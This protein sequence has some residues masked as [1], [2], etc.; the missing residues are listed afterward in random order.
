MNWCAILATRARR[1]VCSA[2]TLSVLVTGCGVPAEDSAADTGDGEYELEYL[3]T[4]EPAA[5]RVKV[6]MTVRQSAHLLR[7]VRF[8]FN[9]D[10][11]GSFTGSGEVQVEDATLRWYVPDE[12]GSLDWV[13]S[14]RNRRNESGYDAWLDGS[15]GV[16]RAERVIPRASSRTRKGSSSRTTLRFE[17]PE[18]WSATTQYRER[19]GAFPVD[20]PERRYDEPA[21]W[22]VMGNL[23]VRLDRVAGVRLVVSGPENNGIRR[24]DILAFLNWTLPEVVRLAPEFPERLTIV[25]AADP[26]WRGGLS[27]SQSLYV[28]AERPLLSENG[29]STLLHEVMHVALGLRADSGFDWILEGL[30]EYYTIEVLSRSGGLSA[31][32]TSK[33]LESV[34]EWAASADVLCEDPSTGAQTAKAV[35]LFATLDEELRLETDGDA[36]LDDVLALLM[37]SGDRV[38][39]EIL[40]DVSTRVLGRKPNALHSE[41]LPGCPTLVVPA[42]DPPE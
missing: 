3:L 22:M 23:G 33:S 9:P 35:T 2:W 21:G 27:A 30:A 19:D 36:S 1:V 14:A 18:G 12:G 37:E 42:T 8:E 15:W 6:R 32:R 40:V 13:V 25:S 26:M 34:A 24:L 31:S 28:H 4:P 20:N 17:L 39:L 10:R 16:M 5:G 7:E 41:A 29:T 38:N 11:Y